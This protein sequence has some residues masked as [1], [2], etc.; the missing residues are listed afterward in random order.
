MQARNKEVCAERKQHDAFEVK[1]MDMKEKMRWAQASSQVNSYL[2]VAWTRLSEHAWVETATQ[3]LLRLLCIFEGRSVNWTCSVLERGAG[4]GADGP[5]VSHTDFSP[6]SWK[7]IRRW[8]YLHAPPTLLLLM[9]N[10]VYWSELHLRGN[11]FVDCDEA[12]VN[13]KC[14]WGVKW[15]FSIQQRQWSWFRCDVQR[16]KQCHSVTGRCVAIM[17]IY[18]GRWICEVSYN[19]MIVFI[20]GTVGGG[21]CGTFHFY[22]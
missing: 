19:A 7:F 6:V 17:V 16:R 2:Y 18:L 1:L 15:K 5:R 8:K 22:H 4:D 12:T 14:R 11:I 21:N 9:H 3:L 10:L 20:F 13:M